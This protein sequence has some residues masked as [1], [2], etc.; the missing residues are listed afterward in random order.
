MR[1]NMQISKQSVKP[2]EAELG[3]V[4][5]ISGLLEGHVP[6]HLA[7]EPAKESGRRPSVV[8]RQRWASQLPGHGAVQ[9]RY[10]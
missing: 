9:Q 6:P 5:E 2:S 8:C 10:Q 4:R 7:R 3:P 1:R